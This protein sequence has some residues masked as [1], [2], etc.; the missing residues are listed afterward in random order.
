MSSIVPSKTS[1]IDRMNETATPPI[2]P[3]IGGLIFWFGV[4]EDKSQGDGDWLHTAA[5][6]K[7]DR[8]YTLKQA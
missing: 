2:T 1:R 3:S 8:K 5:S 4:S 6:D 7:F